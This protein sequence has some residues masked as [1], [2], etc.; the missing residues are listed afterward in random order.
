MTA[1]RSDRV[2]SARIHEGPFGLTRREPTCYL[3]ST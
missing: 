2:T 3:R 1:D